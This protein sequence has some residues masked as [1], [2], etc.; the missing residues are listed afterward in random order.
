LIGDVAPWL[1]KSGAARLENE[2]ID[3]AARNLTQWTPAA[4]EDDRVEAIEHLALA[5]VRVGRADP[6]D[7]DRALREGA[8]AF[9]PR[10]PRSGV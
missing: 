7:I 10:V 3:R 6:A 4:P 8:N 5:A 9:L 1:N 2:A